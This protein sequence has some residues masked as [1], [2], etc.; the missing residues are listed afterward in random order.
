MSTLKMHSP[1]LTAANIDKLAAL[2]PNCVTESA[3]EKGQL[4]TSIDF[5]LLRQELS[6]AVVE[7][8]VERYTLKHLPDIEPARTK[9]LNHGVVSV[10]LA[11]RLLPLPGS[12]W[13]DV[14]DGLKAPLLDRLGALLKKLAGRYVRVRF[15]INKQQACEDYQNGVITDDDLAQLGLRIYA[16][17]AV[18]IKLADTDARA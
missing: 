7:G 15:E 12:S 4:R 16:R 2:F 11:R 1:D 10:R 6:G 18:Q 8:P 5:D 17:N 14:L 13:A 9:E 3:D